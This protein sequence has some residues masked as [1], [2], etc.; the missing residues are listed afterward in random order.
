[1]TVRAEQHGR[2]LELGARVD[3][4]VDTVLPAGRR[5]PT[6]L[7]EQHS[8][9]GVEVGVEAATGVE[10]HVAQ[11]A[12]EQ[13][14]SFAE[15]VADAGRDDLLGQQPA[16]LLD[17]HE[18]LDEPT[19]GL[20]PGLDEH[21]LH[22]GAGVVDDVSRDGPTL[23][24]VAVEQSRRSPAVDHRGELPSEVEGILD[25]EVLALS[26]RRRVDV[27][28]IAGEEHST[29]AVPVGETRRVPEPGQPPG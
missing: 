4:V 6:G 26:A 18:L 22:L 19:N 8:T 21:E 12:P 5:E 1:M 10:W 20:R 11:A 27:R 23:G 14:G 2:G 3:E 24:L 7:V 17:V 16:D 29:E 9:A 28:C 15:V 13:V 25:S